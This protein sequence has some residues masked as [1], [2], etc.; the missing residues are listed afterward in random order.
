MCERIFDRR[1]VGRFNCKRK[2]ALT[3][4]SSVIRVNLRSFAVH[5]STIQQVHQHRFEVAKSNPQRRKDVRLHRSVSADL[6]RSVARKE[7]VR[8]YAEVERGRRCNSRLEPRLTKQPFD[9]DGSVGSEFFV[10]RICSLQ[11]L[12]PIRNVKFVIE[13]KDFDALA[14]E[15]TNQFGYCFIT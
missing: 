7:R 1:S 12:W 8:W 2:S 13:A 11:N 5:E 14:D 6:D 9:N 4:F 15:S 10:R 3:W